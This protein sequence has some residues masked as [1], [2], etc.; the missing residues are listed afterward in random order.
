MSEEQ[1]IDVAGSGQFRRVEVKRT[2]NAPIQRVWDAVT[3]SDEVAQW[4]APGTIE[5]R[6][7][8]MYHLGMDTSDCDG[9]P[10][11]G[12]IKVFQPPYVLEYT[13]N[14]DYIPAEGLVRIDLTELGPDKTLLVLVQSVPQEDIEAVSTGW[15]EIIDSLANHLN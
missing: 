15:A 3:N 14:D 10:L 2:L 13:W 7:G 12:T 11:E 6:E 8:G 5:P 1:T 4:W 9:L